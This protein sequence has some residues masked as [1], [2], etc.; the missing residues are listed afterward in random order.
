MPVG[1]AGIAAAFHTF[2]RKSCGFLPM[3]DSLYFSSARKATF[4]N[5]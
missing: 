2:P 1:E 5:Q 4:E 3:G